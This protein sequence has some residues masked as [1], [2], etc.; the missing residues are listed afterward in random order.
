MVEMRDNIMMQNKTNEQFSGESYDSIR[1]TN[2]K[3]VSNNDDCRKSIAEL[4]QLA[5]F[6]SDIRC[7]SFGRDF[8][9]CAQ[10]VFSLNRVMTS[11]EL[12]MVSI[13]SCCENTCIAD[14]NSLLRK[15]RDDMFFYLYILV[16]DLESNTGNKSFIC[17]NM[18]TQISYWMKN[19]L[20]N[21]KIS[22]VLQT[23]AKSNCLK[24]AVEKYNLKNSFEEIGKHLNDYMHSNGYRYYNK[25][26]FNIPDELSKDLKELVKNT[27]YIS[28]AFLFLL[29]LCAP[30]YIMAEDYIDY[31]DFQQIPPEYSQYWIAP[32]VQQ[33]LKDNIS[34]IDKNCLDYLKNHTCMRFD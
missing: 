22:Q 34:L 27:K 13:I 31:L 15:Y 8:I 33:F 24:D 4:K 6:L 17:K 20:N 29:I 5:Q 30:H 3:F 25:F 32:F 26:Y 12:T 23:I 9:R 10:T 18:E 28:V 21:F 7:L 11:L 16:Y 19:K 14:A 2:N 1:R